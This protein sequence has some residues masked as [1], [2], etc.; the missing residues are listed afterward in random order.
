[1][2]KFG[3]SRGVAPLKG[4]PVGVV[5]CVEALWWHLTN[6]HVQPRNKTKK[7][8]KRGHDDDTAEDGE[9]GED[10]AGVCIFFHLPS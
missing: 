7:Q 6:P 9:D 5:R 4:L 10:E 1:V 3:P 2:N 8:A